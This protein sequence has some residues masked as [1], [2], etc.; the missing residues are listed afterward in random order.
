[1]L[2][3][4]INNHTWV[5]TCSLKHSIH[6][7]TATLAAT[8][9]TVMFIRLDYVRWLKQPQN[10]EEQSFQQNKMHCKK[11]TD[12]SENVMM[13]LWEGQQR[14]FSKVVFWS[15]HKAQQ[16]PIKGILSKVFLSFPLKYG[17]FIGIILDVVPW[18][19][20]EINSSTILW[21][22]MLWVT[23]GWVA[24]VSADMMA[25]CHTSASPKPP[26]QNVGFSSRQVIFW[27]TDESVS[28]C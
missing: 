14:L 13:M 27:Q 9:E 5:S 7:A 4:N 17:Y 16:L 26:L 28:C 12:I 25:A 19:E 3:G 2:W 22:Y 24:G 21:D 18:W 6:E 11:C 10:Q 1:M 20:S 15:V 23:H 8:L